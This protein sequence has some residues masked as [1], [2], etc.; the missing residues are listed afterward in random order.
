MLV[1]LAVCFISV[2]GFA[3]SETRSVTTEEAVLLAHHIMTE[4]YSYD[5]NITNSFRYV[6]EENDVGLEVR[7]YPF[8]ETADCFVITYQ[9]DGTLNSCRVPDILDLSAYD[10]QAYE[11]H[12]MFSMYTLEEKAAYSEEY[13]P[14]IEAVMRLNPDYDGLHYDY[15]RSRYGLPGEDD[16]SQET[17]LEIAK[18]AAMDLLGLDTGW[19]DSH[20]WHQTFFDVTDP[21]CTLWKFYFGSTRPGKGKYVIRLNSKTGEVVKAF[22]YTGDMPLWEAL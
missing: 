19:F 13:I 4:V 6:A 18:Q 2:N 11:Q 3:E 22:K 20:F 14:K 21:E 8:A 1:L 9:K 5:E 15:T 16:I 10:K 7:V 17:A 12:K